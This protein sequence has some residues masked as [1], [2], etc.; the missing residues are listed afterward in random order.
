MRAWAA[1]KGKATMQR[2]I[3][4]DCPVPAAQNPLC[5]T[6]SMEYLMPAALFRW[7]LTSRPDRPAPHRPPAAPPCSL[8]RM[9][10]HV[11]RSYQELQLLLH[12]QLGA[13]MSQVPGCCSAA[14]HHAVLRA[15]GPGDAPQ[16]VAVALWG[17][18][19]AGGVGT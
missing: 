4:L 19:G 14:T 15:S 5:P 2:R 13:S 16:L 18:E 1:C 9:H 10:T 11:F 8:D 3:I 17:R 12:A 7:P 6:T